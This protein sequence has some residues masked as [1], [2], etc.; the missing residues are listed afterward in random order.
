MLGAFFGL[1]TL[2]GLAFAL[3]L[4]FLPSL[5]AM[6]HR[7]PHLPA[8]FLVNLFLGWTFIGWAAA[9]IWACIRPANGV[10]HPPAY[11]AFAPSRHPVLRNSAVSVLPP[12]APYRGA[13]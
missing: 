10:V 5:I 1:G 13:R 3:G 9:L 4:L 2:A 7:H 6:R 8:I 11:P 12:A